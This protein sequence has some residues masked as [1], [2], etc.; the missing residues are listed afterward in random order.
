MS[1]FRTS[2]FAKSVRAGVVGAAGADDELAHAAGGVGAAVGRLR[3]E[4]LVDVVVAVQHD[5]RAGVVEGGPEGSSC[6]RRDRLS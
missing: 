6:R 5:V 4:P 1:V 2:L 3:R